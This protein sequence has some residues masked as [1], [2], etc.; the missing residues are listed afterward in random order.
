LPAKLALKWLINQPISTA[1]PGITTLEETEEDFM[2]NHIE[3]IS[4]TSGEKQ[5]INQLIE[6]LVRVRCRIC[7]E[8]EPCPQA[9][10]IPTLLGTDLMYDH[11]RT[12]GSKAFSQF[13]WSQERVKNYIEPLNKKISLIKS[14]TYCGKC[15]ESCPYGLPIMNMLH[16]MIGPQEDIFRIFK[17]FTT[18]TGL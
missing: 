17:E 4:L 2:I 9:I 10:P 8:C 5:Q 13:Q 7:Q 16:D 15:E 14:C 3:D 1:V 12:M 18:S 6:S 11:Y